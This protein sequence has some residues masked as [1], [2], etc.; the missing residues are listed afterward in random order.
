MKN[1]E[2]NELMDSTAVVYSDGN[3]TVYKV[4]PYGINV[5]F[6]RNIHEP[7]YTTGIDGDD[8]DSLTTEEQLK[9]FGGELLR[10]FTGQYSYNGVCNHPSEYIGGGLETHIR[11]TQGYYY[12]VIF[13]SEEYCNE[14]EECLAGEFWEC[15]EYDRVLDGWGIVFNGD[16]SEPIDITDV[17]GISL[18]NSTERN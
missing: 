1:V 18:K 16:C 14:C 10:G 7:S 12:T 2:L 9:I 5:P 3:G 17:L 8:P 4:E 15:E 6:D 13:E 11:E